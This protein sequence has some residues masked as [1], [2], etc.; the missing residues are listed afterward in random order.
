MNLRSIPLL[1]IAALISPRALAAS[2]TDS[3]PP[4]P[5]GQEWK[6]AWH[7]EFD[8]AKLDES[9]WNRLGDSKRRDGFWI[10][11]DAF[12]NGQGQ[13]I[14]RTRKDGERFTCGAVNTQGKFEHAFGYYVARCKMPTQPGHW[15]A[16]WLMS[17]G[18]NKVGDDGRDGT[19]IDIMEMPWRDG[20]L[21]SNL[22]WDG[23]GKAHKSAGTKFTI[24]AV[25]NGFHTFSLLWQPTNYVFYVDGKEV[26]R[27]AA[28]GVSQA[29]EFIKLTEEI[30]KWGGD[31]RAAQLPDAF[32]VDYVRVYDLVDGVTLRK[33]Q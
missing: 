8:S 26:W 29:P 23:Y 12:L 7:D 10:K 2:P 30:G 33:A 27:S 25:T 17:K 22:H 19:E 21:T 4:A 3:V 28:G 31:I 15:P 9:K 1:I 32:E 13:L 6:L 18:V 16:F 14:L 20:K 11:D 24:P 5:A